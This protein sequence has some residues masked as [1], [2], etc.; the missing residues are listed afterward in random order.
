MA[1]GVRRG[2]PAQ[3]FSLAAAGVRGTLAVQGY[4]F[5]DRRGK[6]QTGKN[7]KDVLTRDQCS[8]QRIQYWGCRFHILSGWPACPSKSWKI[9][10]CHRDVPDTVLP[11]FQDPSG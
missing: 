3:S 4:V 1:L 8:P 5:C 9:S 10:V 6:G 11:D 7:Y 2:D